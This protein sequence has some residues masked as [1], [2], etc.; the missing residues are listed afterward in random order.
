VTPVA[1]QTELELKLDAPDP[2][3]LVQLPAALAGLFDRV[4]PGQ[5]LALRD[6]YVDTD[7]WRLRRAGFG[8]RIRL[9]G[10]GATLTIKAAGDVQEGWAA[11]IE[12]EERLEAEPRLP[13]PLPGKDLAARFAP[14]LRGSPVKV[15]VEIRKEQQ[16]YL[17]TGPDGIKAEAIADQVRVAGQAQDAEFAEIE[18]E[19]VEGDKD[20]F[21]DLAERVRKRLGLEGCG[22]SK[23]ERALELAGVKPPSLD[24]DAARLRP[25][26]RV[27]S[28]AYRILRKHFARLLWHDPGARL[29]MDPE[30][31]HDM[32]VAARRVMAALRLFRDAL[33][34]R[35]VDTLRREFRWL[36]GELGRVRDL[37]VSIARLDAEAREMGPDVEKAVAPYRESMVRDRDAAR[38]RMLR[39]LGSRRYEALVSRVE[40]WLKLGPPARPAAALARQ[41]VLAAAPKMIRDGLRRTLRTGRGLGPET[42]DETLHAFRRQLKRA[43]YL[44]EFFA[45]LYGEEALET[46]R[47]MAEAQDALGSRQ[48]ALV[49]NQSLQRFATLRP[50]PRG[51]PARLH[52]CL[53]QLMERRRVLAAGLREQFFAVFRRLDR[54]KTLA[55]LL[56][57]LKKARKK[58]A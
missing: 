33:P 45:D 56:R 20:R 16:P 18:L 11:R 14:A 35:R 41:P 1:R 47:R 53:G 24:D 10:G 7:D 50:V 4:E 27:S 15:M 30:R 6:L 28:A 57:R 36:A 17:L 46:A 13:C 3:A 51:A 21:R 44:C 32:R 34:Q 12:M 8:C 40:R 9:T 5:P 58:G 52:L 42:P 22:G 25:G 54:R 43:R 37:D 31:L 55:P 19:L 49:A 26:D 2:A 23:L 29:G 38:R 39:S 48:D